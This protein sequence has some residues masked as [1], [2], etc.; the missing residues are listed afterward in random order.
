MK[1]NGYFY[2]VPRTGGFSTYKWFEKL[3]RMELT[4]LWNDGHSPFK[5]KKQIAKKFG[6]RAKKLDNIILKPEDLIT[7]TW[8]RDPVS[9]SISTYTYIKSHGGAKKF[10]G[11]RP[12]MT[13]SE[14]IRAKGSPGNYVKFFAPGDG[15]LE[16]AIRNM[17][18][19]NFIGFTD[20][21]NNDMNRLMKVFGL[22]HI[23]YNN[24]KINSSSGKFKPSEIDIKYLKERRAIDYAL[25]N[26][27]RARRGLSPY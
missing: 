2:H 9:H 12:G 11:F 22:S 4:R 7:I 13:F 21:F 20:N 16:T 17:E 18:T 6:G 19:I 10:R 23:K 26:E 14:W 8:L 24:A 25:V 15:K 5:A 3:S 1:K 27:F